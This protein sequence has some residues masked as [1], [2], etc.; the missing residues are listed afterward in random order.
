MAATIIGTLLAT[1]AALAAPARAEPK[2]FFGSATAA[3]QIEGHREVD[4]RT[5]SIWDAFDTKGRSEIV[6]AAKPF[7]Q[8]NVHESEN[9]DVADGDYTA[10]GDT[11]KLLQRYG[12]DAY[13]MSLSWTRIL[14][15]SNEGCT[16]PEKKETCQLGQPTINEAGLEHYKTVLRGLK[17]AGLL[18]AVTLWH[19]DTPLAVEEWAATTQ[20]AETNEFTET[21][22]GSAWLCPEIADIFSNYTQIAT[23]ALDEYVDHWITL[24]EPLTV[25]GVGYAPPAKHAPG[26]CSDRDLCWYGNE[27]IEPYY[28]AKNMMRAHAKAFRT[29]DGTKPMGFAANADWFEPISTCDADQQAA[30]NAMVWEVGLFWDL[31]TT[32]AWAPEIAEA[33][34]HPRLPMLSEED[35][36]L[37]RGA[38]GNVYYQNMYTASY[39]WATGSD[40]GPDC[41]SPDAAWRAASEGPADFGSDSAAGKD[42]TNPIT[43][44]L[45]GPLAPG[46]GWLHFTPTGLPLLQRWIAGRYSAD[47][48]N[49]SLV[50]TENGWGGAYPTK[51]DAVNDVQR[52]EYYRQYIGNMS[53]FTPSPDFGNGPLVL[54]EQPPTILGYFAWS[55]MDNYEWDD[56]YSQRFGITYVEYCGETNNHTCDQKRTP[57]MT[58]SWFTELLK[59]RAFR[60]PPQT[61]KTLPECKWYSEQPPPAPPDNTAIELWKWVVVGVGGLAVVALCVGVVVHRRKKGGGD[62]SSSSLLDEPINGQSTTAW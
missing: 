42:A 27:T 16:G 7:G 17:E 9:G 49:L 31:L 1:A 19:W 23:E 25:T 24:N 35:V 2:F 54:S 50:V 47:I 8:P 58:A 12:F 61:W 32:G 45:I 51:H 22:T 18:T 4:G 60:E 38:H 44:E 5:P 33:V 6:P 46:S 52:C 62:D 41:P 13:R 10:F 20:C 34:Q 26:R 59:D 43:Q 37:L 30:V 28:V 55:L 21:Q 57:K 15:Y 14:S 48:A 29:Y 36:T 11:T 3:Y 56:G 53:K 40:V 39:A